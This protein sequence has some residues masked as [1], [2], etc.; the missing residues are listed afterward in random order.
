M[1][2][3]RHRSNR[4]IRSDRKCKQKSMLYLPSPRRIFPHVN[5]GHQGKDCRNEHEMREKGR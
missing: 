4:N 1:G 5:G 3:T 2:H